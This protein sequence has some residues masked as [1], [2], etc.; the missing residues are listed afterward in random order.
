MSKSGPPRRTTDAVRVPIRRWICA[1]A[2]L[3]AAA[4]AGLRGQA[5]SADCPRVAQTLS[6]AARDSVLRSLAAEE[7]A[8]T[9]V[10]RDAGTGEPVR[11]ATVMIEGT[12]WAAVTAA[13]GG[14][15]LRFTAGG[16]PMPA[17]PM[18]KACSPDMNHLTDA[19][20][21]WLR[22]PWDGEVVIGAD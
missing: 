2:A 9:G 13:D 4:P 10:V 1:A 7:I 12:S 8:L 15:L 14:Y 21:G 16:G 19:R 5:L 22:A 6:P 3:A 17:R 11:G 20:E 18:V